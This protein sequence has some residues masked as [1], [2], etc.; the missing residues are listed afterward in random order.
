MTNLRYDPLIDYLKRLSAIEKTL[1]LL[2]WDMQV[3][4]PEHAHEERGY[5]IGTLTK[6]H[7]DMSVSSTLKR[8]IDEYKP[9]SEAEE[10]LLSLVIKDYNRATRFPDGFDEE[11]ALATSHATASWQAARAQNDHTIF[12]PDFIK[13]VQ[14]FKQKAEYIGYEEHPYDALLSEFDDDLSTK[15]VQTIIEELRPVLK[16]VLKNIIHTR[17][18]A[19]PFSAENLSPNTQHTF[20]SSVIQSFGFDLLRGRQDRSMHPF[21]TSLGSSDVRITSHYASNSLIGIFATFHEAG[22]GIYDQN[23]GSH[24]S[25]TPLSNAASLSIHESQSRFWENLVGK[26]YAFWEHYF[27]ILQQHL[28]EVLSSY[29]AKQFYREINHVSP[30]SIR[31]QADEVTYNLHIML[32]TE[33]EIKLLEGNIHPEDIQD[34]WSKTMN[35]Y[36]G[37]TPKDDN[38]GFLQDI[39]WASGYFGYFPTYMTGNLAASQLLHSLSQQVDFKTNLVRGDFSTIFQWLVQ[40]VHQYGSLYGTEELLQKTTGKPLQTSYFIEYIRHKYLET[41]Y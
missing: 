25:G 18:F 20:A 22:H 3:E 27:P 19:K 29:D 21:T 12:L 4:L 8:L 34:I 33:L 7:H 39:H 23:I 28:P 11:F 26:S 2:E 17:N 10:R 35:E 40:N 37:I 6:I 24:F 5:Q 9:Q 15:K 16:E 14:L 30:S 13:L 41:V 38:E 32:R 36:L 1:N 31:T